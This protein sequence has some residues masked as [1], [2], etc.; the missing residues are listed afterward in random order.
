[1]L[2][3]KNVITVHSESR[4]HTC[5]FQK[6]PS[7]LLPTISGITIATRIFSAKHDAGRAER[8]AVETHAD[9]G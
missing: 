8:V 2:V 9:S 6:S 1:M 7:T 4:Q 5:I 3:V